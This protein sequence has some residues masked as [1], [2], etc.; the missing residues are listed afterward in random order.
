MNVADTERA[1]TRLSEAGYRL[2]TSPNSAD[3]VIFNTCSVRARAAQKVFTRIGEVRKSRAGSE[4][5]IGIMGCVAQLEGEAL[6][7]HSSA[8]N[9][10]V[11]TRATDRLPSLI[12]NSLEGQRKTIDLGERAEGEEWNVSAVE[13][14]SPHV[15]FVPIIEG[16]NKFCTYCIVPFSRGREK[17]RPASE[18]IAEVQ[19]LRREG[20]REVHLI[21][22]NVNSYRPR[23]DAGLEGF[24]GVT[25][26]SRL[27]RAVA[28]TQMERIKFTT[29]FPRDFHT[30]IV[31][32]LDENDNLCD[33][34]HLPVQSGS[35]RVLRAMRRGYKVEDYLSRV[36]AIKNA[37]RRLSLTSDIIIGFPGETTEE[38][39]ET[40][41]LVEQCQYDGLYIFKYSARPGTPAASL[42]DDISKEEK[43]ARF[44]ALESLQKNI[45]KRIYQEYVGRE[46]RVLVEGESA[47]SR[48]DMTGHSTC[49]KVVNFPGDISLIGQEVSVEIIAAKANSLYG[50][51][52]KN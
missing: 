10:V 4:P 1:A 49:H 6:F 25:P 46:V 37:R 38:F 36:E 31:A 50:V 9:L 12:E 3:V 35:N 5:K 39:E 20:Y 48:A 16:C 24:A 41:R 17:S 33:W 42:D 19:Q 29:S 28:A 11:G 43:S 47:K 21:G 13:R 52:S 22:Q 26:F 30:D 34:V 44:L 7:D 23:T 8:V 45:Q 18:I 40:V 15:A 27:L 32:A 51:M 2:T 14:R